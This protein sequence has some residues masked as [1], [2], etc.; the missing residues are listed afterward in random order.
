MSANSVLCIKS[1]L[2][3]VFDSSF[4]LSFSKSRSPVPSRLPI[5]YF[6]APATVDLE[7]IAAARAN[8]KPVPRLGGLQRVGDSFAMGLRVPHCSA[9]FAHLPPPLFS[10]NSP[11]F[12]DTRISDIPARRGAV[13]R[14]W[15]TMQQINRCN[16]MSFR[17]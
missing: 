2:L 4:R 12:N 3:I 16:R 1:N 5:D 7:P 9:H 13:A 15:S 6:R 10:R 8:G 17:I 14:G 11:K